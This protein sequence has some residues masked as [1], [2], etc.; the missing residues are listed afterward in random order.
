MNKATKRMVRTAG[1]AMLTAA[2]VVT[3]AS[4]SALAAS[5]VCVPT[6]VEYSEGTLL[7]QCVTEDAGQINYYAQTVVPSECTA[8]SRNVETQKIWLSIAQTAILSGKSV[9]IYWEFCPLVP[10]GPTSRITAL[11]LIR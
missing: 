8:L 2:L 10:S 7:V 4:S 6:V 3:M 1:L 5:V 11:D 9:R